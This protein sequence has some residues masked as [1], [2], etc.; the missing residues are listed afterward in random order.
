MKIFEI[1]YFTAMLE[2]RNIVAHHILR[3]RVLFGHQSIY[4]TLDYIT[5]I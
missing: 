3:R 1:E 5:F 4:G 2:E